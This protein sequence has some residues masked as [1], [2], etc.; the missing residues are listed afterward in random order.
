MPQSYRF[1][2]DEWQSLISQ[3]LLDR[4]SRWLIRERPRTEVLVMAL[5]EVAAEAGRL[6][7]M[8]LPSRETWKYAG[9]E[10]LIPAQRVPKP[11]GWVTI[12]PVE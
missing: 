7:F 10:A 5:N 1:S 3:K 4:N 6:F 8:H 9:G 2:K 11:P 12:D